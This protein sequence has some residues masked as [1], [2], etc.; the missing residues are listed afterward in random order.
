[1]ITHSSLATVTL[2][3]SMLLHGPVKDFDPVGSY[4]SADS[5]R[6]LI[7]ESD[8]SYVLRST[9][10]SERGS[11]PNIIYTPTNWELSYGNWRKEGSFVVLS[12]SDEI[13][14]EFLEMQI[15]ARET[16]AENMSFRLDSPCISEGPDCKREYSCEIVL[17]G[18]VRSHN[19]IHQFDCESLVIPKSEGDSVFGFTVLIIPQ[20][21]T[22]RTYSIQYNY[23]Y[24]WS[25]GARHYSSNEFRIRI[26]K[27][28]RE[29]ISYI[30]FSNEYMPIDR[31]GSIYIRGDRFTKMDE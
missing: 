16:D 26:D 11:R 15:D 31:T 1:M 10:V 23:L 29:Y 28:T 27:F 6:V 14:G 3:L 20:A 18:F 30:R 5:L 12:A 24:S 9:A 21:L 17:D 7:I 25:E 13:V 22:L 2:L 8:G 19:R 4:V